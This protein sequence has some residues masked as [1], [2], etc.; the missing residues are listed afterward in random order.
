MPRPKAI[1]GAPARGWDEPEKPT[2]SVT[3]ATASSRRRMALRSLVLAV[4]VV[5]H[6]PGPAEHDPLAG[7][8]A[9]AD[10]PAVR[11]LDDVRREHQDA[12]RRLGAVDHLVEA[13]L[14]AAEDGDVAFPELLLAVR[15]AKRR[16]PP[17][18][19]QPLLVRVV[20]ME[21]VELVAGLELVQPRADQLGIEAAADRHALRVP[22]L[23]LFDAV[24]LVAVQVED[25]HQ[26][27]TASTCSGWPS[28]FTLCI[29][30]ATLPSA[31]ITKVERLTPQYDL[32]PN[33]FSPHTPYSSATRCS[34]S[35]RSVNGSENFSLNFT[36][37]ASSSGLTPSTT[38]PRCSNSE[39]TS[40]KPHAS[41][42][43]PGVSSLG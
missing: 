33:F 37:D 39:Y 10:L 8:V 25:V 21:R 31:S 38:A 19:E 29:T 27:S 14:A 13:V 5:E 35:A 23:A 6:R 34:G 43:Q 30:L 11:V 24:P 17:H 18:D 9:G 42:V 22:A 28:G 26:G 20:R 36:C 7:G 41:T 4:P 15:G 2:V 12:D 1:G 3:A 32:P 40:R 16:L